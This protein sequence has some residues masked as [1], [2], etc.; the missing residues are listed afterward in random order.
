VISGFVNGRYPISPHI[1]TVAEEALRGLGPSAP[2]SRSGPRVLPRGHP[3]A[4]PIGR[5]PGLKDSPM[6][7]IARIDAFALAVDG[8]KYSRCRV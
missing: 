4:A 5:V 7:R 2:I 3:A 1:Q 8:D 6:F